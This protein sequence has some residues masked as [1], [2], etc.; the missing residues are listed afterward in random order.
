MLSRRVVRRAAQRRQ[1][2]SQALRIK[3][4]APL[5]LGFPTHNYFVAVLEMYV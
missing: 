3:K 5:K 4:N 1:Y 2:F